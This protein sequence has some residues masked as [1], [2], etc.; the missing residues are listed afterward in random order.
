[1]VSDAV[2]LIKSLGWK[3]IDICGFSMGGTRLFIFDCYWPNH[4]Y[5]YI[6]GMILQHLLLEPSL[7]FI[8]S[9]AILAATTT[10]APHGDPEF[11]EYL[12][13]P[14]V[15]HGPGPLTDQQKMDI[16]RP[17]S[18]LGYDKEWFKDPKNRVSFEKA[19]PTQIYGRPARI[20][21]QQGLT[22]C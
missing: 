4:A 6:I 12:T 1:M 17:F 7:P 8:V 13:N 5:S 9:H 20:I 2:A 14:P 15:S 3:S 22:V 19:L 18:E 16:A 21:A 10:K 11:I